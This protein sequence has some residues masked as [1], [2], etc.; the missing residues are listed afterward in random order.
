MKKQLKEYK[1]L[2]F[3][4]NN[5]G[6][7]MVKSGITRRIDELGRLV[8]PK[9]IRNNLK[10]KDNDQV[11]I[12][13]VDNK[14]I[15]NKFDNL[16]KDRIISIFLNIIR[17]TI[18]KNVL[19]TSREKI[20]DYSLINKEIIVLNEELMNIIENRKDIIN[21]E[22]NGYLYNISPLVINGDLNG[23]LIIYSKEEI[24]DKELDII[25]FCQRFLEN[26]LE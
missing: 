23:S 4:Q 18:N 20:I 17:K 19:Y 16:K 9:E 11:E 25:K 22:Y 24:N 12:T 15:L 21:Y 1:L 13:V 5:R 7:Y 3:Y 14:I 6:D 2:F 10:I 26:Y 8:I